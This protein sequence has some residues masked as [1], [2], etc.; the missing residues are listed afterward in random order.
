[1][2]RAQ[3]VQS[4]RRPFPALLR[5]R[6]DTEDGRRLSQEDWAVARQLQTLNPR[7]RLRNRHIEGGGD[8]FQVA[9]TDFLLPIFE[10]GNEAAVHP[11]VFGHV[12]LRPAP[13]YDR[14]DDGG[15][16]SAFFQD[17]IA[18]KPLS[19]SAGSSLKFGNIIAAE[20]GSGQW[21]VRLRQR[22]R[23]ASKP[24]TRCWCRLGSAQE[25]GVGTV[26]GL[27]I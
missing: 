21:F 6:C 5:A 1:M 9:D 19:R 15:Y 25:A 12:E 11:D 22:G 4:A 23:I 16:G 3:H 13:A 18:P 27:K 26:S 20:S 14:L 2:R 24:S 10:V 17:P 8:H 7:H